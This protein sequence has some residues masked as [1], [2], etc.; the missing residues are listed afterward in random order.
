MPT[1]ASPNSG[2]PSPRVECPL[3]PNSGQTRVRLNP[4]PKADIS[5]FDDHL[6][7]ADLGVLVA[8]SVEL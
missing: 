1:S 4:Q 2:H 7:G 6:I 3:F 8:H 5:P